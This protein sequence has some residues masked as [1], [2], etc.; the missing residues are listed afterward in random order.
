MR[1]LIPREELQTNCDVK[2]LSHTVAINFERHKNLDKLCAEMERAIEWLRNLKEKY[3][4]TFIAELW[5]VMAYIPP[6][7]A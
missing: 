2:K 3:I 7:P 6:L 5:R 1:T 4:D